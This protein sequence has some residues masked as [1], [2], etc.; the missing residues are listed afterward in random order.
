MSFFRGYIV[1]ELLASTDGWAWIAF[2]GVS[3]DHPAFG[4]RFVALETGQP[5]YHVT[6]MTG[7]STLDE[8]WWFAF[9]GKRPDEDTTLWELKIASDHLNA[10][11]KPRVA[12]DTCD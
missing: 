10:M 9:E 6:H 4:S 3:K 5:L 7:N 12:S 1:C 8:K 2:L 11:C